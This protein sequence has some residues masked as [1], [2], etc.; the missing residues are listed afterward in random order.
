GA[1]R[2]SARAPEVS[3]TALRRSLAGGAV[4]AALS[5]ATTLAVSSRRIAAEQTVYR[6]PAS[7]RC[8][9][10]TLNR[11][12]VLP[13]TSLAVAPLPGSYDASP[14][15]QISL[16]GAPPGALGAVSARGSRSGWHPGR[17]RAYSQGDGASF[18]PSRPFR[19]G[20]AVTVHGRLRSGARTERFAYG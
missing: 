3:S 18:V 12:A 20:E 6:A 1:P 9:P 13:G 19:P 2:W 17:L 8:V 15:T 16:L 5:S 4:L 14:R 10:A 7:G 11:S